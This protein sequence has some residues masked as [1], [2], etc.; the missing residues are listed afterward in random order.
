MAVSLALT[1]LAATTATGWH[2]QSVAM[3]VVNKVPSPSFKALSQTRRAS[4]TNRRATALH[5]RI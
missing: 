1:A 2:F 4:H 5:G 3:D